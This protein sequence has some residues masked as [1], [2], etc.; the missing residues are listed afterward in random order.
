M[1]KIILAGKYDTKTHGDVLPF[2]RC[3][4]AFEKGGSEIRRE[5]KRCR[6]EDHRQIPWQ[7]NRRTYG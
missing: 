1:N 3:H 2:E 4:R 5:L 7:I 6:G